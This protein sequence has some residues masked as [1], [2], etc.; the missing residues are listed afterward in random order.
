M[1]VDGNS[2]N[3]LESNSA[4]PWFDHEYKLPN[5]PLYRNPEALALWRYTVSRP[6]VESVIMIRKHLNLEYI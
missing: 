5:R 4:G 1:H 2:S 6:L 3:T